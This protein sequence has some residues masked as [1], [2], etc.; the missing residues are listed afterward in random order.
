MIQ[1][2]K[3]AAW[4]AERLQQR[5]HAVALLSG[6]L[7]IEDRADVIQKFKDGHHKVLI[8]TNVC[9]RGTCKYCFKFKGPCPDREVVGDCP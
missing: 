6:E 1:T 4:L 5:G 2:R 7:P 9:A 3:S 8:T